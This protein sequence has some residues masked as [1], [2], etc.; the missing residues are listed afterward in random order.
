MK[1]PYKSFVKK[2]NFQT[3]IFA[4]IFV[5]M[6]GH[7]SKLF[8]NIF[9]DGQTEGYGLM[10]LLQILHFDSLSIEW[11]KVSYYI[12]HILLEN[13][14]LHSLMVKHSCGVNTN[15]TFL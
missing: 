11:L 15:L 3:V 8:K 9:Y 12:F 2:I 5:T 7:T 14:I 4:I 6:N 10:Q 1:S 13:S